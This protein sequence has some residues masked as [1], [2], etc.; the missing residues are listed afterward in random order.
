MSEEYGMPFDAK[1]LLAIKSLK[2]FRDCVDEYIYRLEEAMKLKAKA[3]YYEEKIKND[4]LKDDEIYEMY[5]LSEQLR[6][7]N[8]CILEVQNKMN[9]IGNGI[10]NL[11]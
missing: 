5:H 10:R 6:I 3:S 7:T 11:F 8:D 9:E 1:M 4:F 2:K